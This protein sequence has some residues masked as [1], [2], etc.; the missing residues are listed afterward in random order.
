[1]RRKKS[2]AGRHF[3]VLALQ[4]QTPSILYVFHETLI[5]HK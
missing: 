4:R 3:G 5:E 1:M 2:I